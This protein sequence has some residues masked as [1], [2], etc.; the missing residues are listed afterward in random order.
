MSTA[1][2]EE[3]VDKVGCLLNDQKYSC[4]FCHG[5]SWRVWKGQSS[6]YIYRM[7]LGCKA[8]YRVSYF[9]GCC[10]TTVEDD[11]LSL[12]YS[13]GQRFSNTVMGEIEGV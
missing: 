11:V 7:W 2:S 4:P 5:V 9:D 13:M 3:W 10:S 6:Y 1:V 12:Q 8:C